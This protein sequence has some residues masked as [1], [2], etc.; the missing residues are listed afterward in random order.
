MRIAIN[1]DTRQVVSWANEPVES[2]A[3]TRSDRFPVEVR[4]IQ[5]AGYVSLPAGAA[6]KLFLK[7]A[8]QYAA[9]AVAAA[10]QWSATGIGGRNALYTFDLNLD[11]IQVAALFAQEPATVATALEIEWA[12]GNVRQTSAPV[13]VALANEY[14][15]A[16]E[17]T[18]AEALDLRATHAQARAG[19][20]NSTWMT[21]LTTAQA[22]DSRGVALAIALG[23]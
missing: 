15:R 18:P 16:T 7:P 12:Y 5:G 17:G 22:I 1:L 4:F 3:M 14:I 23:G 10:S 13:S 8:G 6:G 11:T 2:L 19:A 20:D 21:P 9:P